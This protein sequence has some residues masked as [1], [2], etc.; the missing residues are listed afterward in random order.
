MRY[1]SSLVQEPQRQ[2]LKETFLLSG[3]H[4]RRYLISMSDFFV[5]ESLKH[6]YSATG[7]VFIPQEFGALRDIYWII[8]LLGIALGRSSI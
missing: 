7:Y 8:T 4:A 1:V 3:W 5:S 6:S 2:K